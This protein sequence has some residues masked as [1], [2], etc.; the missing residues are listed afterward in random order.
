GGGGASA[1]LLTVPGTR[2]ALGTRTGSPAAVVPPDTGDCATSAAR[3]PSS[4]G[5]DQLSA[6][7]AADSTGTPV[8]GRSTPCLLRRNQ[9]DSTDSKIG[10]RVSSAALGTGGMITS[11][12]SAPASDG[13]VASPG[14]GVSSWSASAV[15]GAAVGE[16]S[17]GACPFSGAAVAAPSAPAEGMTAGPSSELAGAMLAV[18]NRRSPAGTAAVS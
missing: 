11:A 12:G 10:S 7:A 5:D 2:F 15:A 14:S 6:G 13:S 4:A 16:P 1:A 3:Q 18:P 8:A 17:T 9:S